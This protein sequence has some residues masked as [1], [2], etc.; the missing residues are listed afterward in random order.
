M[1]LA[2]LVRIAVRQQGFA[3][4]TRTGAPHASRDLDLHRSQ[5]V[6]TVGL[7]V[8]VDSATARRLQSQRM[9]SR[10]SCHRLLQRGLAIALA[11][12]VVGGALDWGHAGGD[13]QESGVV[14][15][16]H[17]HTAHRFNSAPSKTPQ[18]PEHCFICHSLRAF[19]T[20]LTANGARAT[21]PPTST[22]L[23]QREIVAV[24]STF[25]IALAARAPPVSSL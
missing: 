14:L 5:S 24:G 10:A 8:A 23:W 12:I 25:D 18:S 7:G 1:S 9:W 22:L 16:H 19:H 17:D 2:K 15:V 4:K 6:A 20:S 21:V 13:D 3:D 11:A